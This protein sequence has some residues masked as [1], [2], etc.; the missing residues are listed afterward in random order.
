MDLSQDSKFYPD[1]M[2]SLV[3][4]Q[5]EAVLNSFGYRTSIV[6]H[7]DEPSLMVFVEQKYVARVIE[8]CNGMSVIILFIAFVVA[9]S[10]TFKKTFI[11]LLAGSVLIY[12]VNLIRIVL[13]TMGLYNYPWRRE[14]MHE[15]IFPLAI[16]G[17]VFLLWMFWVN[18]FSKKVKSVNV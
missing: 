7:Y 18:H 6:P 10:D 3:G 12:A 13:L 17:M 11:F 16:Y 5:T 8:G 15:V 4:K 14:I 2:T 9:F 1:Y